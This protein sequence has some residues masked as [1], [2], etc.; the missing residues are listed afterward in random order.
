[1]STNDGVN[2][3]DILD[4]NNLTFNLSHGAVTFVPKDPLKEQ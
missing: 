1:M 4:R 3:R 2:L